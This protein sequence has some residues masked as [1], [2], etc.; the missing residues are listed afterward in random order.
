MEPKRH[1][2]FSND[3]IEARTKAP[4]GDYASFD[5]VCVEEDIFSRP[6]LDEL[7]EVLS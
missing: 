5:L 2:D 1:H 4:A 7:E 3:N 6:R